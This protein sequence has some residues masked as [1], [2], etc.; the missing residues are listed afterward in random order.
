MHL[1][2]ADGYRGQARS[3]RWITGIGCGF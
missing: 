3:Y 1:A 2:Q